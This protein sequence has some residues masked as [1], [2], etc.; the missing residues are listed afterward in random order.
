[1]KE[2]LKGVYLMKKNLKWFFSITLVIV[3][4]LAMMPSVGLAAPDGAK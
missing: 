3:F 4:A 1:V 2:K